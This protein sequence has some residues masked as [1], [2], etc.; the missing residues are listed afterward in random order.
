[1]K[2]VKALMTRIKPVYT[3]TCHSDYLLAQPKATYKSPRENG[4]RGR[5]LSMSCAF[6][7]S[8]EWEKK[9]TWKYRLGKE[10]AW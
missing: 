9:S 3:P 2:N 6:R 7:V 10:R 1:M 4:V 8:S 5:A